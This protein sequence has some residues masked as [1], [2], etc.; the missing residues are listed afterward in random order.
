MLPRASR[1]LDLGWSRQHD[2][3]G[4]L[5]CIGYPYKFEELVIVDLPVDES[6]A[7]YRSK[8]DLDV[9][10]SELGTVRHN[11]HS[12]TD[13][14]RYP[15]ASFD[16]V[17]RGESIEHITEEEGGRVI[18]EA[19]RVLKPGGQFHVADWGR[20]GNSLM[21]LLFYSIRILDRFENTRDN[22]AGRLPELF[23]QFGFDRVS[24][25]HKLS[26]VCG[27]MALYRAYKP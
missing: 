9:V 11:Y 27:T 13:L 21:K 23:Q 3:R 17:V 4:A 8:K 24:S 18:Q 15:D 12:M 6:H 20:P 14:S 19:F 7:I 5:F 25:R 10:Q 2:D 22:V 26:T 1:I 16:M